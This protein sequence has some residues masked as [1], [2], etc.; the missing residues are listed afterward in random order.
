ME[1]DDEGRGWMGVLLG[2]ESQSSKVSCFLTVINTL[3]WK[4]KGSK[5]GCA[6]SGKRRDAAEDDGRMRD[7]RDAGSNFSLGTRGDCNIGE[8]V[9]VST[10]ELKRK[11]KGERG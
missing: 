3:F 7:R 1:R 6:S 2:P 8:G 11:R 5:R 4:L 10:P 9:S